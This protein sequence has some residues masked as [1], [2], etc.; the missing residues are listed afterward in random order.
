MTIFLFCMVFSV[1]L[2]A[3]FNSGKSRKKAS[4]KSA[5]SFNMHNKSL[6]LSTSNGFLYKGALNNIKSHKSVISID[7]HSLYFQK[8]NNLYV[9]PMKHKAVILDKFKTPQ[10]SIF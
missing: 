4:S 5:L 10:K 7:M 6:N 1:A 3:T 9:V 8:G 2:S